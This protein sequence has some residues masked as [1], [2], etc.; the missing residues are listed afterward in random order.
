MQPTQQ[1]VAA[2]GGND[3]PVPIM[4]LP[5]YHLLSQRERKLCASSNIKPSQY[6]AYKAVLL[7]DEGDKQ[8]AGVSPAT[9]GGVCCP[10]GL[11]SHT[12]RLITTFMTQAGWISFT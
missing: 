9:R 11:D 10:Q 7:K 8:Q 12:Q 2:A 4:S 6:I 1:G 3:D 5:G